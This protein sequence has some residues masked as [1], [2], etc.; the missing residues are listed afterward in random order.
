MALRGT[1]RNVAGAG[2]TLI[3]IIVWVLAAV[4][5]TSSEVRVASLGVTLG[6]ML[7]MA[8][9]ALCVVRRRR[10]RRR[11]FQRT[12]EVLESQGVFGGM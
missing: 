3:G 2:F 6:G 4:G 12:E 9:L 1:G 11:Y 10:V 7:A 5:P 8:G